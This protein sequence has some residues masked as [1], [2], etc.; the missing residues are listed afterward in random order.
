MYEGMIRLTVELKAVDHIAD[1]V[2]RDVCVHLLISPTNVSTGLTLS[3]FQD[4][5]SF[6]VYV[7]SSLQDIVLAG[8]YQYNTSNYLQPKYDRWSLAENVMTGRS[9]MNCC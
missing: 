5:L 2:E 1:E 9:I 8:P 6:M 4:E 7:F 3:T